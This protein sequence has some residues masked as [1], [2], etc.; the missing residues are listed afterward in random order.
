LTKY[1]SASWQSLPTQRE[2][3]NLETGPVE[4]G[5][6]YLARVRYVS[7]ATKSEWGYSEV[8]D[9]PAVIPPDP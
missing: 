6:S 9:V 5:V 4:R 8:I 2:T 1:P 3:D 7:V